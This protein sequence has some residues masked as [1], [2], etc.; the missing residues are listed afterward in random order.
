MWAV[1]ECVPRSLSLLTSFIPVGPARPEAAPRSP[2]TASKRSG[3]SPCAWTGE[4]RS[5]LP[6]AGL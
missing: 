1:H 4:R 6:P 5:A 3:S 2:A